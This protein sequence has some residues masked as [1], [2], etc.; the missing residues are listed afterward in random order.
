[1]T[2]LLVID[3]D[4]DFASLLKAS[5]EAFG[6]EVRVGYTSG[7]ALTL[8]DR[9]DPD[10][11]LLDLGLPDGDGK[12]LIHRVRASGDVPI[13]VVTSRHEVEER[14]AALDAGADDYVLKPFSLDELAARV[15][16]QLRRVTSSPTADVLRFEGFEIDLRTMTVL[17][18]GAPVRFTP[19]ELQMVILLANNAGSLVTHNQLYREVWPD[20]SAESGHYVRVYI[21]Q[22]RRKLGDDVSAPRFIATEHSFGYRWL[23][24]PV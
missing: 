13:I 17:S 4:V 23:P 20:G 10:L 14:V 6:H 3:D 19:T 12:D 2:D 11:L 21:Q 7:D 18:D 1:M 9:G 5:L 15:R 8:L 22:I 24:L 16:A